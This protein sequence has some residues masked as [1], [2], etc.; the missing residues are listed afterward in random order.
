M[1]PISKYKLTSAFPN[2]DEL[3]SFSSSFLIQSDELFHTSVK[4]SYNLLRNLYRKER[5]MLVQYS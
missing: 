2:S 1:G 4:V 5:R 3:L